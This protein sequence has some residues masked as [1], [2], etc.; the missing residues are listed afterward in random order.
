MPSVA[1]TVSVLTVVQ[2]AAHSLEPFL[3]NFLS[4]SDKSFQIIEL[5][6][7]DNASTDH[8]S[9]LLAALSKVDSRLK[10]IR[11][12]QVE[13][14]GVALRKAIAEASGDIT[15]VFPATFEYVPDDLSALLRPVVVEGADAVLG[16][17]FLPG[18]YRAVTNFHQARFH[19]ALTSLSNWLTNTFLSDVQT[20]VKA[21]HTRLLKSIPIESADEFVHLELTLKLLKR[22]ARVFEAPIRYLP[23]IHKQIPPPGWGDWLSGVR[24]LFRLKSSARLFAADAYGSHILMNLEGAPRFNKWMGDIL[25]PHLGQRVLEIGSGTGTLTDQFVPRDLYFASDINPNYLHFLKSF[26]AGRPYMQ[27]KEIDASNPVFFEGLEGKFDTTVMVNV[28]EHVPDDLAALR[29]LWSSLQPGGK[30]VILVPQHPAIYGT[31]DEVLEHRE[32]YTVE[33]LRRVMTE[34]GFAVEQIFDFNRVSVPGWWLNGRVL[35][36]TTFSPVQLLILQLLMP[37]FRRIDRF[38]PWGGLSIIGIGVKKAG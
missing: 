9:Q 26:S 29:N 17:R 30:A 21:I 24:A 15:A 5:I 3:K 31:L 34:A 13:G 35:R 8:T 36:K 7:V 6:V 28:L 38:F 16:S 22:R 25:R 2:N 14:T 37:V 12:S 1:P 23:H 32:R 18:S 4:L 19:Q 10:G 11:T 27:I 20:P 33:G